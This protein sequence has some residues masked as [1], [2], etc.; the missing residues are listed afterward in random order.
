[1]MGEMRQ[2]QSEQDQGAG[3]TPRRLHRWWTDAHSLFHWPRVWLVD[4][5]VLVGHVGDAAGAVLFQS[6]KLDVDA[7]A[8]V[9]HED[10][11]ERHVL[12]IPITDRADGEPDPR[13]MHP[14][15]EHVLCILVV[16]FHCKR[17][18]LI[19]HAAIMDVYIL[20]CDGVVPQVQTLAC[21]VG[22]VTPAC[23]RARRRWHANNA[24]PLSTI[25]AGSSQKSGR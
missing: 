22:S 24:C 8:G 16:C 15:N 23:V 10:V 3:A 14:F 4:V 5:D 6:S 17:V 19:P 9:V 12:H 20:A 25:Q 7:F 2:L 21:R 11:A 1:M 13:G 18:V